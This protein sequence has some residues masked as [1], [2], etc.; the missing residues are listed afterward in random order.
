ML[1]TLQYRFDST[2]PVPTLEGQ[3]WSG[4]TGIPSARSDTKLSTIE[5]NSATV[6]IAQSYLQQARSGTVLAPKFGPS[7]PA[8]FW[9]PSGQFL[10]PQFAKS[11]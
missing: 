3:P 8:L 1:N 11:E 4:S 9:F 7:L 2:S 5:P 10:F 6:F